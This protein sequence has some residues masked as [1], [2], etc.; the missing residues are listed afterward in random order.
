M[1]GTKKCGRAISLHRDYIEFI[2]LH[3]LAPTSQPPAG[4]CKVVRLIACEAGGKLGGSV[5][6]VL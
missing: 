6:T 4:S 1:I 3:S 2:S 5:V